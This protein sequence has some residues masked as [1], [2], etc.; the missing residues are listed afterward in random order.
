MDRIS[1][2]TIGD[3]WGIDEENK[4]FN[5]NKG[6]SLVI[7]NTKKGEKLIQ[8]I[9]D[10]IHFITIDAKSQNYL[11]ANLQ[12]PSEAPENINQFWEEYKNYGFNYI[13]E[14]YGKYPKKE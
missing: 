2:I 8:E 6:V 12:K 11:Q 5:D 14:K 7:V 9:L 13:I 1:D 3:F 10:G 4:E